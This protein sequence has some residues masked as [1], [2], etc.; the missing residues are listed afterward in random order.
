MIAVAGLSLTGLASVIRLIEWLIRTD[1]RI[2]AQT[3]RW[4]AVGL[5]VLSAPLLLALL[6]NEKWTASMVLAAMMLFAFAWYGPSLLQ[7]MMRH[8]VA[9]DWGS[10][11]AGNLAP[12]FDA[13]NRDP[14]LVRRSIIVLEEYLRRVAALPNHPTRAL[15]IAATVLCRKQRRWISWALVRTHRKSRS[16]TPIDGCGIC[17]VPSMAA[18]SI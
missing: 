8:P 15:R 12:R 10:P 5:A 4:A 16:E 14:E 17:F 1:P 13:N 3:G 11:P 18:Q 6:I 2:I 7:R 9:A